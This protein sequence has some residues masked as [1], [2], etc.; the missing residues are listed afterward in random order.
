MASDDNNMARL[1]GMGVKPLKQDKIAPYR[2]SM[3]KE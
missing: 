2:K 3:I 1:L